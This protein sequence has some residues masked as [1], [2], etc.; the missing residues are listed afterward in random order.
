MPEKKIIERAK[1]DKRAGKV[2]ST[3]AGA[4]VELEPPKK[5]AASKRTRTL[6]QRDIAKGGSAKKK[7]SSRRAAPSPKPARAAKRTL[8]REGTS[9]ASPR[10][11]SRQTRDAASRRRK[12]GASA[13]RA[14][15]RSDA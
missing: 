4:V 11:L 14:R 2:P 9:V 1:R 13:R 15:A 7:S 12:R 3:Q 8:K 6:A 10:A 5:G